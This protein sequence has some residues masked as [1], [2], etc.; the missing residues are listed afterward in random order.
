MLSRFY[1]VFKTPSRGGL[2]LFHSGLQ[3]IKC[4]I[5]SRKCSEA[6]LVSCSYIQPDHEDTF[7][8][9]LTRGA[10]QP[11]QYK[12][13]WKYEDS[14]L[15]WTLIVCLLADRHGA[16]AADALDQGEPAGSS[17]A[18]QTGGREAGGLTLTLSHHLMGLLSSSNLSLSYFDPEYFYCWAELQER[19]EPS[20]LWCGDFNAGAAQGNHSWSGIVEPE[21]QWA[22]DFRQ[23][24]T[25]AGTANIIVIKLSHAVTGWPDTPE[26]SAVNKL[27]IYIWPWSDLIWSCNILQQQQRNSEI[28]PLGGEGRSRLCESAGCDSDMF[29]SPDRLCVVAGIY[30]AYIFHHPCVPS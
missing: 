23:V 14:W 26:L 25:Q 16:G 18:G 2:Y 24:T 30:P 8:I 13:L 9:A 10:D 21:T 12:A 17:L 22:T 29:R 15:M 19:N 1:I 3:T 20:R 5:L 7:S 28:I 6:S 27:T 4:F 11:W